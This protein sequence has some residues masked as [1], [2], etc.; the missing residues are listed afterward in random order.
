MPKLTNRFALFN[1]EERE[2]LIQLLQEHSNAVA[3]IA[4]ATDVRCAGYLAKIE[5]LEAEAK[6]GG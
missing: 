1:P 6:D 2:I 3:G 4:L 5:A